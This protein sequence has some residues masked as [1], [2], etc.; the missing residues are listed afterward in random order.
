MGSSL[1]SR[2][3]TAVVK[4]DGDGLR[5]LLQ[6]PF[7]HA[8]DAVNLPLNRRQ[9]GALALATR[10]GRY[11]L[12]SVLLD[13]GAKVSLVGSVVCIIDDQSNRAPIVATWADQ[14]SPCCWRRFSRLLACPV[15]LPPVAASHCLS[16]LLHAVTAA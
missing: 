12:M 13:A 16:S 8:T 3:K 2:I 6:L 15:T 7:V 11:D 14:F 9:D 1:S 4:N 5:T 10:L